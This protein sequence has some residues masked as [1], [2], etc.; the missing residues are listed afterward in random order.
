LAADASGRDFFISYAGV[1]RSWAEWI[2]VELERAGFS[3]VIQSF[4]FRPGTDFVH[5]MQR[6][7]SS[8]G[9][10]IAVLSPAYLDSKFGETEWRAAFAKD[11]TGELGLLIPV[12]VQPC[13]PPGLLATRVYVDFVGVDEIGA[14]RKLLAAVD[15]ARPRPTAAPFPGRGRGTGDGGRA[16]FPG[17]G[18]PVANLPARNGNFCGRAG[19]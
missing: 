17:L 1:N 2:A 9:R 7:A 13:D 4:D 14:R 12:R 15:R 10:T 8:A 5:E 16:S 18:P 19:R 11:P 3:T 6:A